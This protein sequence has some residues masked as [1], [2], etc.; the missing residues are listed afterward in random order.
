MINNKVNINKP[1][2][3]KAGFSGLKPITV[4]NLIKNLTIMVNSKQLAYPAMI[5]TAAE[6]GLLN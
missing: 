3:L 5:I 1:H 2:V 6:I 4:K